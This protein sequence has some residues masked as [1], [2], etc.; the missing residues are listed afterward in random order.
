MTAIESGG[1]SGDGND[2]DD[3]SSGG[4]KVVMVTLAVAV[5]TQEEGRGDM[6]WRKIWKGNMGT[7]Y[8]VAGVGYE[9]DGWDRTGKGRRDTCEF[10]PD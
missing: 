10:Q 3:G 8:A 5:V 6:G 4:G 2:G 9:W 7:R 1:G